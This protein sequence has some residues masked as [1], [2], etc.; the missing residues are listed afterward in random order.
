MLA[1]QT[2]TLKV[3]NIDVP[4]LFLEVTHGAELAKRTIRVDQTGGR[5]CT[6]AAATLTDDDGVGLDYLILDAIDFANRLDEAEVSRDTTWLFVH[7]EEREAAF[8]VG[9]SSDWVGKGVAAGHGLV[10]SRVEDLDV[11]HDSTFWEPVFALVVLM[12][13]LLDL[14]A[15]CDAHLVNG[16]KGG[17]TTSE[18]KNQVDFPLP[19]PFGML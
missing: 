9:L 14:A 18:T 11:E 3:R 12:D 8:C 17:A 4:K 15:S 7:L 6:V 2:L 10:D 1:L 16:G 5:S 13:D 19:H